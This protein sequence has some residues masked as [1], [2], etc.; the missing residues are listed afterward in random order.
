MHPLSLQW[1]VEARHSYCHLLTPVDGIIFVSLSI[2]TCMEKRTY[3]KMVIKSKS[4]NLGHTGSD[5]NYEKMVTK[6]KSEN[7]GQTGSDMLR[8]WAHMRKIVRKLICPQKIKHDQ[9]ELIE[10]PSDSVF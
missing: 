1:R 7:L 6:S 5:C 10:S 3:E 2:L 8:T 9:W 4:E